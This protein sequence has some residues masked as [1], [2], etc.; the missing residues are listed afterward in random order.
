MK[1]KVY[2][3]L[4]ASCSGCAN[5]LRLFSGRIRDL[6]DQYLTVK[7]LHA[8]ILGFLA[9]GYVGYAAP[10]ALQS[11]VLVA[12][13]V[14]LGALMGFS[15]DKAVFGKERPENS[16]AT[17]AAWMARRAGVIAACVLGMSLGV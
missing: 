1:E 13:K 10:L 11:L 15:I 3:W 5:R 8:W 9:I 4:A 7:L 2:A 16:E 6:S 12:A 17:H 14:W